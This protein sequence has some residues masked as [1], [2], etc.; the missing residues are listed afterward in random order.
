MSKEKRH[1][2]EKKTYL[3][4]S[5]F[6]GASFQHHLTPEEFKNLDSA[7]QFLLDYTQFE[8]HVHLILYSWEDFEAFLLTTALKNYIHGFAPRDDFQDTRLRSNI[9]VLGFL[10]SVTSLR[11]HFPNFKILLPGQDIRKHFIELW[12]GKRSASTDFGFFERV[13]NFA[14]HQNQPVSTLVTG[15]EWIRDHSLLE[16]N[17][18]LFID[19]EE[20]CRNRRISPAEKQKYS[21]AFQANCDV[22]LLFR[23][24]I[25]DLGQIVLEMRQQLAKPLEAS[26]TAYNDILSAIDAWP[27]KVGHVFTLEG[28]TEIMSFQIFPEFLA[29]IKHLRASHPMTVNQRHFVSNRARGHKA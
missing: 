23:Q 3:I 15:G 18:T 13:R 28:D 4:R 2:Q 11:D 6:M 12:D 27:E 20:V 1:G 17:V 21:S 8:E 16:N 19:V 10:N 14:Q 29:R 9:K 25:A 5:P 26:M 7:K 22:S 24:T